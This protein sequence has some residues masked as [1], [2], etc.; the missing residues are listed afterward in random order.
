MSHSKNHEL[1]NCLGLMPGDSWGKKR[2]RFESALFGLGL[3]C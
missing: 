3:W 1:E 2:V